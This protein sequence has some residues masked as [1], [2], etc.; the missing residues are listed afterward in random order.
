MLHPS[1]SFFA[2]DDMYLKIKSFINTFYCSI[3]I[4]KQATISNTHLKV[5]CKSYISYSVL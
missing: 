4:V 2:K 5:V 3:Q 1:G